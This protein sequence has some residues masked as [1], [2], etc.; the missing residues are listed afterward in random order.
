ML[1][2]LYY[3]KLNLD[4]IIYNN[5]E[6]RKLNDQVVEILNDLKTKLTQEEYSNITKLL[7][8]ITESGSL[9]VANTFE[10]GFKY[11]AL[12]MIEILNGINELNEI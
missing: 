1:K 12:T 9:E 5:P 2:N 3:G 6:Y 11:G 10:Y 4:Q 8:I 7:D